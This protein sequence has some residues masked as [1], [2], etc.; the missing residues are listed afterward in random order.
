MY[1]VVVVKTE[2]GNRDYKAL[3]GLFKANT[4]NLREA[5]QLVKDGRAEV[6]KPFGVPTIDDL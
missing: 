4:R 2:D 5:I 1:Y 6:L 3:C